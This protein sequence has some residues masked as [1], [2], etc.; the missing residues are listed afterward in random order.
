M[1][2]EPIPEG[3]DD[4]GEIAQVLVAGVDP[5]QVVEAI[6]ELDQHGYGDLV[7]HGLMGGQHGRERARPEHV[8]EVPVDLVVVGTMPVALIEGVDLCRVDAGAPEQ[9]SQ[10]HAGR[11]APDDAA[12]YLKQIAHTC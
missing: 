5:D 3:V 7:A 10:H 9:V 4:R 2:L 1:D 6:G 12:A 8:I 11:A